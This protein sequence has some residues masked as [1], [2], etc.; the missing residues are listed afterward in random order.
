MIEVWVYIY[1]SYFVKISALNIASKGRVRLE[2]I[3]SSVART[4]DMLICE[5]VLSAM[6]KK[7]PSITGSGVQRANVPQQRPWEANWTAPP[8]L[9]LPWVP[10]VFLLT[11]SVY[12]PFGQILFRY[13][14]QHQVHRWTCYQYFTTEYWTFGPSFLDVNLTAKIVYHTVG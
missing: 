1:E 10:K 14:A 3:F 5:V 6:V 11:W 7:P 2:N 13:P 4:I 8:T 9:L 12:K